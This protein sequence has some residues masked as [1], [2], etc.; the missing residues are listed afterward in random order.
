MAWPPAE[1]HARRAARGCYDGRMSGSHSTSALRPEAAE[2]AAAVTERE[3][4]RLLGMPRGRGLEGELGVRADT[5]R[6]WY[7]RHGRPFAATR[8]V[9]VRD[10]SAASVTLADGSELRSAGLA[11]VLR[12]TRGRAVLVLAVSAGREVAAE[13]SRAWAEDRPDEA[14]FLDR[15]ATAVTE[16]LVLE[17]SGAACRAAS[18]EGETLLPPRS[19]GCGDFAIGDQHRLMA[20]LGGTPNGE[21]VV[22]GPIELLPSG[23]LDPPHSLLAALG[24]TRHALE[25]TTPEALCRGCELDPCAFRRAPS[26]SGGRVRAEKGQVSA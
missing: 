13:V 19:P 9:E 20:L 8:R 2:L 10:V 23:A 5:A 7:A 14:Y 26:D 16:A 25:A 1:H 3:L 12:T 22:L 6:A 11:A 21:R 18:G 15:F 17:A 24:V 4:L